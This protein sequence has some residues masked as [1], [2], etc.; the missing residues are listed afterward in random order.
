[1]SRKKIEFPNESEDE[2][3]WDK[4]K[5]IIGIVVLVFLLIGGFIAHQLLLGQSLN[6][7]SLIPK[8]IQQEVQGVSSQGTNDTTS[9][10]NFTLPSQ[11]DVQQKVQQIQQQVTHLNLQEVAS[12]SPQIQQIIQQIQSIPQQ[13]T[14]QFKDACVRLCNN[15]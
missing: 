5:I 4:K 6:P 1:M 11:Q 15:L 7:L 9:Q 8:R 2:Y 13:S 12:S 14:G 3:V 10:N